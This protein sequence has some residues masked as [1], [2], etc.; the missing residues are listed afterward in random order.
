[1]NWY[2]SDLH[3][4]HRNILSYCD[5][6]YGNVAQMNSKLIKNF[7][8]VVDSKDT[9]YF[10]GDMAMVGKTQ[11]Q[12]LEQIIS[13]MRGTKILIMGN[14]D[15]MSPKQYIDIG[16]NPKYLWDALKVID[17]EDIQIEFTTSVSPCV[18]KPLDNENDEDL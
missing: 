2:T 12:R 7:N 6:P 15:E 17:S 16:F 9:I 13:K 5:R 4:F 1:M 8:S 11:P 14:H 10:L 18:I 3:F